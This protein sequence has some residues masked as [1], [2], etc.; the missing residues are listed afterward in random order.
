MSGEL[1]G[2][3]LNLRKRRGRWSEGE[4]RQNGGEKNVILVEGEVS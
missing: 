1:A 3:G 2:G 4:A